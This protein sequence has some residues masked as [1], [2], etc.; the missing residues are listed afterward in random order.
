MASNLMIKPD[1]IDA[2]PG[3]SREEKQRYKSGLTNL[4]LHYNTAPD[5]SPQKTS[6]EDKI[7][8]ASQ[9]IMQTVRN[10][11]GARPPG[12][13][14]QQAQPS[15]SG[16]HQDGSQTTQQP[17]GGQTGGQQAYPNQATPINPQN[18]SQNVKNYLSKIKLFPP[19]GM[20]AQGPDFE[21]HKREW[22]AHAGGYLSRQENAMRALGPIKEQMRQIQN[23]QKQIPQE[24]QDKYKLFTQMNAQAQ[25]AF[26]ELNQK[27]EQARRAQEEGAAANQTQ[28]QQPAQQQP[29]SGQA[30]GPMGVNAP[31]QQQPPQSTQSENTNATQ[32]TTQQSQGQFAQNVVPPQTTQ[33]PT[34]QQQ[35]VHTPA[36][37][38]PPQQQQQ[39]QQQIPQ[40][41]TPQQATQNFQ[42]YPQAAQQ[43]QQ[44]PQPNPQQMQQHP[45]TPGGMQQPQSAHPSLQRPQPL[46]QADAMAQAARSY[47]QQQAQQAQSHGSAPQNP[48]QIPNPAMPYSSQY[49]QQQGQQ[50]TP[51]ATAFHPGTP[52]PQQQQQQQ[53]QMNSAQTKFPIPKN[54][55]P[56]TSTSTPVPGPQSRPSMIGNNMMMQPGIQK[57]P[58]FTLEGEGDHVLS[59]RKL[60]E[61]V[62]QVT[63]IDASTSTGNDSGLTPEVEEAVLTLADNF[64]DAVITSACKIAKMRGSQTLDIRDIQVILERNYGIRI[65]GYSLDEVRTVRK[66]QPAQGWQ[67]KMQAVQAGKVMGAANKE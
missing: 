67:Q 20:S 51:T 11:P 41:A 19:S 48:Q 61:L 59:K 16:Q 23:A 52:H 7:K 62:R 55:P 27:N 36:Q 31:Q 33:N 28:A 66:F 64:V 24:L 1:S 46:S 37:S 6:L 21:K 58:H 14:Q 42:Q 49:P 53:Q 9:K 22:Y 65:P 2:L 32:L 56:M 3:V 30:G 12:A 26:K 40:A 29:A 39:Q 44:R 5:G 4:W 43:Q 38:Q 13:P 57:P 34:T 17:N 8:A 35:P 63:G 10:R 47:S 18:F 45:A 60:D 25:T 54:L 50:S 15:T